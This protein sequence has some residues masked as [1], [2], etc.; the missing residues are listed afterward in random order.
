MR[1]AKQE[2]KLQNDEEWKGSVSENRRVERNEAVIWSQDQTQ[3]AEEHRHD[4]KHSENSGIEEILRS[5][6]YLNAEILI[7]FYLDIAITKSKTLTMIV[8]KRTAM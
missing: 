8:E 4:C 1:N 2:H 3:V 6:Y 5:E 7:K